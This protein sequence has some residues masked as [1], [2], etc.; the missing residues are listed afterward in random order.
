MAILD[1][2]DE[3]ERLKRL[4]LLKTAEPDFS[5]FA[6]GGSGTTNLRQ[7]NMPIA[8]DNIVRPI[9]IPPGTTLPVT[10]GSTSMIDPSVNLTDSQKALV[11]QIYMNN[12]DIGMKVP[13]KSG[14]FTD[15]KNYGFRGV[16]SDMLATSDANIGP[17]FSEIQQSRID[18][19]F[20]P[21]RMTLVDGSTGEILYKTNN[22]QEMLNAK[23]NA[24]TIGI[25]NVLEMTQDEAEKFSLGLKQIEKTDSYGRPLPI[26][27]ITSRGLTVFNEGK[28]IPD[29]INPN[30][31]AVIE[32]AL[33]NI[34]DDNRTYAEVRE[35]YSKSSEGISID[36]TIYKENDDGSLT[37][38]TAKDQNEIYGTEQSLPF[39]RVPDEFDATA[40]SQGDISGFFGRAITRPTEFFGLESPAK[41]T[42]ANRRVF[43]TLLQP[44]LYFRAKQLT[45][46]PTAAELQI[47]RQQLPS[48]EKPDRENATL[49]RTAIEDIQQK[50]REALNRR[51]SIL[52]NPRG[53]ELSD[54][55]QRMIS[56]GPAIIELLKTI[57][58]DFERKG[59]VYFKGDK[60]YKAPNRAYSLD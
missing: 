16:L 23:Q 12:P 25:Q 53:G 21:D 6:T 8:G 49:T 50:L 14:P 57:Y 38:L 42:A 31:F 13:S 15:F 2:L 59:K 7:Y 34:D 41:L 55:D 26:D 20:Y 54:E 58:K 60:Q 19:Q 10:E 24:K 45:P 32:Q 37:K 5:P 44:V 22:K 4:G 18:T 43:D 46:K 40:A 56:Q 35:S 48:F 36:S 9:P 52:S 51:D 17:T 47:Q 11:K 27:Q 3:M 39:I 1:R 30:S 28:S 33:I 29:P